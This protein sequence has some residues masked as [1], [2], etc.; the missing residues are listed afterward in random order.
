MRDAFLAHGDRTA[1][2]DAF[3]RAVLLAEQ[4][5]DPMLSQFRKKLDSVKQN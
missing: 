3:A 5:N 4:R 2:R 1:A